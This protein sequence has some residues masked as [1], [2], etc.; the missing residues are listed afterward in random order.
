MVPQT[1]P[2]CLKSQKIS[3]QD[4]KKIQSLQRNGLMIYRCFFAS[5]VSLCES[6]A[7][8]ESFL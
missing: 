5:F 8:E 1:I 3:Q 7:F 2:G 4:R 6:S